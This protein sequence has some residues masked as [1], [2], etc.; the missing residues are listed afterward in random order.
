VLGKY[1]KVLSPKRAMNLQKLLKSDEC[2]EHIHRGYLHE[3]LADISEEN[4]YVTR[5]HLSYSL[6]DS[7]FSEIERL[8]HK[9]SDECISSES[10]RSSKH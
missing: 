2:T 10:L 3:V 1:Y 9:V 8:N 5:K 6:G 7:C 4:K